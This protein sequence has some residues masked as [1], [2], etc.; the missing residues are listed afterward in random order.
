MLRY[1]AL[2]GEVIPH[3]NFIACLQYIMWDAPLQKIKKGLVRYSILYLS[4]IKCVV[5]E[6]K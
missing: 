5:S 6:H 1:V 4:K 2:R 3:S